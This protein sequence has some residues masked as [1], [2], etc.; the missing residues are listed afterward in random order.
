M[1][2][3]SAITR[4]REAR[5]RA[6][7]GVRRLGIALVLLGIALCLWFW[8]T[9]IRMPGSSWAGPF[10]PLS[11]PERAVEADLRRDV[12]A[13]VGLYGERSV[14]HHEGLTG[15]ASHLERALT[16]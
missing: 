1:A 6:A 12:A 15:A 11:Q 2:I 16:E 5:R 3:E 14:E 13:L 9:M 4:S 10:D 7:A 8:S